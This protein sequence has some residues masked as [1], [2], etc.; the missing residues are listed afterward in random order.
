METRI[1]TTKSSAFSDIYE[2]Q[3]R[4]KTFIN[5]KIIKMHPRRRTAVVQSRST[6]VV[7]VPSCSFVC[8]RNSGFLNWCVSTSGGEC[9][10]CCSRFASGRGR[11]LGEYDTQSASCGIQGGIQTRFD[12]RVSDESKSSEAE[13]NAAT[14][15]REAHASLILA[16]A[17]AQVNAHAAV[18]AVPAG[19][20]APS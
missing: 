16:L 2:E 3:E 1:H 8:A 19:V 14:A 11:T 4:P 18:S 6:Y 12:F 15:A 13:V 9:S 20:G 5:T 17:Q 7:D 10:C